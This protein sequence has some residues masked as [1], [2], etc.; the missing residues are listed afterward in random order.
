MK[1]NKRKELKQNKIKKFEVNSKVIYF[2]FLL[3]IISL[4]ESTSSCKKLPF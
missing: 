3:A 4:C 2:P 1:G